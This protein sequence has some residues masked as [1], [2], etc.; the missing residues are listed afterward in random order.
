[1]ML[2]GINMYPGSAE[3][4]RNQWYVIAFSHEVTNEPI[5]RECLGTPIVLFRTESGQP[6][7]LFDRCPHRGMKLS[8]GKCIGSNIQCGYHG[9]QFSSE[10]VGVV[11][12]SGGNIPSKM[13]VN[14]Y[15]LVEKWEWIW[16]WMG[17]SELADPALIPNHD[18]LG[19][20]GENANGDSGLYLHV[21]A[22]Y[23]LPHENLV[24]AT[25]IT[26]LH[27]GLID[28]GNVA[29]VPTK[30]DVNGPRVSMRREFIDEPM[31]DMLRKSFGMRGDRLDRILTLTSHAP[32]LCIIENTFKE[33][34]VPDAQ[35]KTN[36][37]VVAVTPE[38]E[39][40]THQFACFGNSYPEKHPQRY[41]DLHHLLM[42]DVV[43]IEDIQRNFDRLG[44]E[45]CPEVSVRSDEGGI[46]T[47]R[48][49]A[50]MI[51]HEREQKAI[52]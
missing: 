38:G 35:E 51:L 48:I 2:N 10:G 31:P 25:H 7:A 45:N 39:R 3:Y 49:I 44:L 30:V 17:E 4:P 52:A 9:V 12:P 29:L 42:E 43:V 50:E 47:R 40:G 16:V 41:D 22:N 14:S 19:L 15:P 11:L 6:V 37:L 36:R 21:K 13:M 32:N 26:F 24:D 28:T 23:L 46:R 18:E 1:M 5:G 8:Q 33:R 27:H 20:T 34:D